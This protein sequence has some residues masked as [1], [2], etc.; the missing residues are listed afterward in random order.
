MGILLTFPEE[1]FVLLKTAFLNS[2][3]RAF[4]LSPTDHNKIATD[5]LLL[6][7]KIIDYIHF[8]NVTV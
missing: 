8:S 2:M 1:V 5:F 4:P 6:Y 3:P 7:Q